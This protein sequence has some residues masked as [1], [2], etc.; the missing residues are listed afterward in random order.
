MS[1]VTLDRIGLVVALVAFWQVLHLVV[2]AFAL[3]SPLATLR[4]SVVL[5]G[6]EDFA[7]HALASLRALA[8]AAAI[9]VLGGTVLGLWLGTARLAAAIAEPFLTA[10][11]ALPKVTLY[12]MILL[13]FG[14]GLSSK[15]AFGALHGIMPITIFVMTGVRSIS[16]VLLKTARSL[17]LSPWQSATRIVLPAALPELL[18]GLR[19]G[20]SLTLLGTLIGEM[21]A[22]REGIGFLLVQGITLLN[23]ERILALTLLLFAFSVLMNLLLYSAE[24]RLRARLRPQG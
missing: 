5:L 22:S 16:P 11:Y 18:S 12:P 15:I 6:E 17:R 3:P 20:L 14:L 8:T 2:G 1:R 10:I 9:A 13:I 24:Y 7:R 21:F 23:G 19:V 4:M